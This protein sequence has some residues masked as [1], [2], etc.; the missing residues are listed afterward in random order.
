MAAK[1]LLEN[2][3]L[4]LHQTWPDNC[5]LC[6][7]D[8]RVRILEEEIRKLKEFIGDEAELFLK[9][10]KRDRLKKNQRKMKVSG[11]SVRTLQEIWVKNADKAKQI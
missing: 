5:C 3:H 11:M 7:G 4:I 6:E 9:A 1:A 10:E 2:Q 8:E